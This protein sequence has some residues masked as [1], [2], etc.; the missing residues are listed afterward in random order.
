M[1]DSD[2]KNF[3]EFSEAFKEDS[4]EEILAHAEE[5]YELT[6]E[7]APEPSQVIVEMWKQ[8]VE[9]YGND[10]EDTSYPGEGERGEG[11]GEGDES[12]DEGDEEDYASEE[13][14]I[15]A[16][17]EQ[18]IEEIK[19]LAEGY[20]VEV[21]ARQRART[22]LSNIWTSINQGGDEAAN[23]EPAEKPAETMEATP[24]TVVAPTPP[25]EILQD[26]LKAIE[27]LGKKIDTSITAFVA[28]MEAGQKVT[29]DEM[30]KE[31]KEVRRVSE[32][33]CS[34]VQVSASWITDIKDAV[35]PKDNKSAK[36]AKAGNSKPTK[37]VAP[38]RPK[39]SPTKKP[40]KPAKA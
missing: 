10:L 9:A 29:F 22:I 26:I 34:T 32:N 3:L 25:P 13:D 30:K 15:N 19:D 35:I 11:F 16:W 33:A 21:K 2:P 12:K 23:T 24:D 18:P 5:Y 8:Y 17:L 39:K 1:A 38:S 31:L 14:F 40:R 37:P 6:F 20:G 27:A 36:P 4:V 7:E 28:R